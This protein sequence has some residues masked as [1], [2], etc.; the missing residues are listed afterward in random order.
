MRRRHIHRVF[1]V[2]GVV[3]YLGVSGAFA[4]E[5]KEST[6]LT[7]YSSA[8][9]GGIPAELYQPGMQQNIWGP[10]WRNQIPGYAIVR[11]E[12]PIKLDQGKTTIRITDVASQIDP[13]TVSFSSLTDA[14]GTHVLEQSFEFDLVSNEKLMQ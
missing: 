12:R 2:V 14:A 4:D 6:S 11:Q 13:T 8:K 1:S 9:P 5:A 3:A 7:I 10:Q